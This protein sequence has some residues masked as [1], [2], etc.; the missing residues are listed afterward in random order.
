MY[1]QQCFKWDMD[2]STFGT[3]FH[4]FFYV[5]TKGR[6]LIADDENSAQP[7][8]DQAATIFLQQE[9]CSDYLCNIEA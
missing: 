6:N 5:M 3:G 8:N 1:G 7:R 9:D 4:F 2:V